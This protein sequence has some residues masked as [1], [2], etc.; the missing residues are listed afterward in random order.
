VRAVGGG[1][2]RCRGGRRPGGRGALLHA[3]RLHGEVSRALE[4]AAGREPLERAVGEPLERAV[5][6]EP[7]ERAVGE[8]RLH[9]QGPSLLT[10]GSKSSMLAGA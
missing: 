1:Q 3:R 2:P 6:R 8:R 10:C 5:V 4:R 9:G 7:L